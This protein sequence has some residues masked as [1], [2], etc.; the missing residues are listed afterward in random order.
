MHNYKACWLDVYAFVVV[1]TLVFNFVIIIAKCMRVT[2]CNI[3]KTLEFMLRAKP[4]ARLKSL[5]KNSLYGCRD[6][7]E[8]YD[9]LKFCSL[10][11]N[12]VQYV[13][14]LRTYICNS[15]S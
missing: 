12:L 15:R 2:K 7:S 9:S 3:L 4:I 13:T 5:H 14:E 11:D 8:F 10:E 1:K 6:Q